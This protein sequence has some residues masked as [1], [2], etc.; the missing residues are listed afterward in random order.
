LCGAVFPTSS[1]PGPTGV[2]PAIRARSTA[3]HAWSPKPSPS[4][5]SVFLTCMLIWWALCSTVII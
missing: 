5:N 2:W 1:L 3:T 4:H